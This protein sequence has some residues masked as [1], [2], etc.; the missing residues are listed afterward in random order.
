MIRMYDDYGF[1]YGFTDFYGFTDSKRCQNSLIFPVVGI[2]PYHSFKILQILIL[3]KE[4]PI[5]F[6]RTLSAYVNLVKQPDAK[7]TR[8]VI[9]NMCLYVGGKNEWFYGGQGAYT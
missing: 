4:E 5:T 3:K 1:S 9:E 6:L 2:H 8:I 7:L